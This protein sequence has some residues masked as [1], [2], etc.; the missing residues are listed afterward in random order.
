[1]KYYYILATSFCSKKVLHPLLNFWRLKFL[2]YKAQ[3][4]TPRWRFLDLYWMKFPF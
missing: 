4:R 3:V 1:L 2:V